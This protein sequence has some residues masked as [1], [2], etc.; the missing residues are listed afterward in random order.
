MRDKRSSP[1]YIQPALRLLVA[2]LAMAALASCS[3]EVSSG[4]DKFCGDIR[5]SSANVYNGTRL[6]THVPLGTT[7]M[8]AIGSFRLCSGTLITPT[9]VVT[10]KH[11]RLAAGVQFCMGYDPENPELC[12]NSTEVIDHPD[13]DL[14]LV[15]LA[16]DVRGRMSVTPIG[17]FQEELGPEWIDRLAEAAG[18]GKT[19]TGSIGTR[20]F[21]A[22]PIVA[23]D[24]GFL[25]IDGQGQRGVC[26]GDSGGPALVIADDGVVRIAGVLSNGD[27]SCLGRDN[28]TRT[29]LTRDW[30]EQYTGP[31][32]DPGNQGCGDIG[33]VG[34]CVD[35][36]AIWCGQD[37]VQAD[38]CGDGASCGWDDSAGGFRCITGPDPCLG[39]DSFGA[40]SGNIARWCENGQPRERDCNLCGQT[41]AGSVAGQGAY[42]VDDACGG[43][44]YL[45][46]CDGDVAEW[47]ENGELVQRDCGAFGQ[48]CDFIDSAVGYYCQE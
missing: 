12:I 43:V 39:V 19:E 47:C 4:S 1:T 27:D 17:I 3:N 13:V 7:Q 24:N 18:Y 29:D 26:F 5:A 36:R 32:D 40:C 37:S 21:T 44:D 30:I 9:W 10:A 48:T 8:P 23:L 31:T 22:E 2:M 14:T 15:H 28:F 11:C 41:C 45:G 38:E 46:R 34:R 33:R 6:P 16:E 20:Y 35:G 42:C 25:T